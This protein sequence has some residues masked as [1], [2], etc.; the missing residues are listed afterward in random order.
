MWHQ[1][2]AA[3]AGPP[4]SRQTGAEEPQSAYCD[5]RLGPAAGLGDRRQLVEGR[6]IRTATTSQQALF[7]VK[8]K[9]IPA[10]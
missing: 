3:A 4:C 7:F 1:I 9:S 10:P 2:D 6:M 5:H 8:S